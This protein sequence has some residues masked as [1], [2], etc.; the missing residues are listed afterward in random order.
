VQEYGPLRNA[1]DKYATIPGFGV[2]LGFSARAVYLR[3]DGA[4]HLG[5]EIGLG[6]IRGKLNLGYYVALG[7]DVPRRW[8]WTADAGFGF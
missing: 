7:D 3:T 5:A 8:R 6:L 1:E 2:A 4:N